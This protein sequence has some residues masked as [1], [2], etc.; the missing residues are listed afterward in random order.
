MFMLMFTYDDRSKHSTL[1]CSP[2]EARRS[3]NHRRLWLATT[4]ARRAYRKRPPRS[5]SGDRLYGSSR[6]VLYF[7]FSVSGWIL[8]SLYAFMFC[9]A[10]PWGM[11]SASLGLSWCCSR[12]H[13]LHVLLGWSLGHVSASLGPLGGAVAVAYASAAVWAGPAWS[14]LCILVAASML[15]VF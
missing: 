10:G 11:D 9:W 12:A 8:A 2:L 6:S 14:S 5:K 3:A 4:V 7:S 15:L 13:M 1:A